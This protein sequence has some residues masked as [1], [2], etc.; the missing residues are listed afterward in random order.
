MLLIY[1]YIWLIIAYLSVVWPKNTDTSYAVHFTQLKATI[2]LIEFSTHI[3]ARTNT[4]TQRN[5]NPETAWFPPSSQ[6]NQYLHL[7]LSYTLEQILILKIDNIFIQSNNHIIGYTHSLDVS[8]PDL[9]HVQH[10]R[11]TIPSIELLVSSTS[12]Q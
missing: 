8:K 4:H 10:V 11:L 6:Q 1:I 9:Q 2:D 3:R 7:D 5:F 12:N